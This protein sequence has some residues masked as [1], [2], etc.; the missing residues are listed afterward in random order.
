MIRFVFLVLATL[1]LLAA[2]GT[3]LSRNLVRA[4][5]HLVAFFFLV[6]CLFVIL[7]AEFIAIV[8][9]LIYVGAVAILMMFGIMLTRNVQ[10]DETTESPG[11]AMVPAALAAAGLLLVLVV[12]IRGE[13][14]IPGRPAWS[15]QVERPAIGPDPA[16]RETPKARAI[17]D[18]G[19]TLG[20]ELM[21]R[22]ALPFEVVGLLLTAAVVGSI[23]LARQ[24]GDLAADAPSGRAGM[25][26]ARPLGATIHPPGPPPA[27]A[28]D[29]DPAAVA[30]GGQAS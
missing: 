13:K 26:R 6:A 23:A 10:G 3:V 2:L 22:Y 25:G 19:R 9:V 21:G 28:G 16:L 5:L 20:N 17:G 8:Q 27:L 15:S 12:G 24:E 7:E 11:R 30:A 29:P 18:M 4:A 1:G 14:G